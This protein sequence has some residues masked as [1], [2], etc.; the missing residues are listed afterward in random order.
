VGLEIKL[1][2]DIVGRC[3]MSILR[4][5]V[6]LI[7]VLLTSSCGS[8]MMVESQSPYDFDKT[9][10]TILTN[11]KAEHWSN[12]KTYD[13]QALLLKHGK[14]DIGKLKVIKLCHPDMAEAMF[15]H[16]ES[17]YVAPMMP[18]SIAIYEKSDGY[19]YV[20]HMN[21]K[22]MSK[23]FS[24]NVGKTLGKISEADDRILNF[25]E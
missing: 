16:D 4:Y 8:M 7:I 11:A 6:I 22:L 12:P 9:Y 25:L 18:C 14:S 3:I 15:L 10:N 21:L 17:K 24:R 13:V 23:L 19:T 2:L 1:D 5:T 20:S